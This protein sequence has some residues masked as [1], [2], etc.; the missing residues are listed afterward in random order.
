MRPSPVT[1]VT[2]SRWTRTGPL[3]R[4]TPPFLPRGAEQQRHGVRGIGRDAG[5]AVRAGAFEQG[6]AAEQRANAV[7]EAHGA[8]AECG[9]RSAESSDVP[10]FVALR[11]RHSA[12]RT[13]LHSRHA[14]TGT[15]LPGLTRS[16]GSNTRRRARIAAR[17]SGSKM[18]GM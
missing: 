17:E 15:T 18:S 9:M 10:R 11:T 12:F 16:S 2:P 3:D 6:V 1:K 5:H 14:C 7:E 13:P 8:N 4:H